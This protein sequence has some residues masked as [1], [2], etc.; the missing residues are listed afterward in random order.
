MSNIHI[1]LILFYVQQHLK[2]IMVS[3][4]SVTKEKTVEIL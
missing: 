2:T 4:K 3:V 1:T